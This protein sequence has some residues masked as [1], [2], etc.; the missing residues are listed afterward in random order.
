[1]ARVQ[2]TSSLVAKTLEQLEGE[3]K[4]LRLLCTKITFL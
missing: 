1:M 2:E 3:N 4:Y